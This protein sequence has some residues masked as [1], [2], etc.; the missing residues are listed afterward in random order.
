MKTAALGAPVAQPKATMDASAARAG[1]QHNLGN[2]LAILSSSALATW[3]LAMPLGSSSEAPVIRPGP[4]TFRRLG[5]TDCL[6]ADGVLDAAGGSRSVM[7][8]IL[9][10]HFVR[11]R[12]TLFGHHA[13]ARQASKQA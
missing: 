10:T 2:V 4:N 5:C 7:P 13:K 3:R 9:A 11:S 1:P 6:T 12:L 8:F